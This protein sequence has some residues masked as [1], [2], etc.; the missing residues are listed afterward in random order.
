ME[1]CELIPDTHSSVW[2]EAVFGVDREIRA[3]TEGSVDA[4]N[5]TNTKYAKYREKIYHYP[6][7]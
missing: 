5:R 7:P 1:V 2:S 3:T 6:Y 4:L